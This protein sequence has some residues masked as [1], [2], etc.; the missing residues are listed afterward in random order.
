MP[1]LQEILRTE[2]ETR[3][4]ET[5]AM[6][7]DRD[8]DESTAHERGAP[9]LD[10]EMV[11]ALRAATDKK[12]L[13]PVLLDLRAVASFTEHFLIVSGANTRQVQAI[14]DGVVETLKASGTRAGR[15]EGYATAE[16]VLIDYGSFIVH[17]FEEK[18][19]AFYDLERLWRDAARIPLPA[20]DGASA[21]ESSL[22]DKR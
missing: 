3:A 6:S 7:H 1:K 13:N 19:R 21:A 16:W 10:A 14:A 12:A 15:V 18:A 8:H 5:I 17:I 2:D 11:D 20:E 22:N 4:P 9:E